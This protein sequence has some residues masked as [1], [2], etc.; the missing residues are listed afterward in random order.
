M[1]KRNIVADAKLKALFGKAKADMFE[2]T[3]M[4]N[5]HLK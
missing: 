5:E 1:N 2:M 3:K 4:I